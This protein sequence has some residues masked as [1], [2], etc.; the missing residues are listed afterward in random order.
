MKDMWWRNSLSREWEKKKEGKSLNVDDDDD[1]VKKFFLF[2]NFFYAFQGHFANFFAQFFSSFN[3]NSLNST[4]FTHGICNMTMTFRKI[5]EAKKKRAFCGKTFQ[6][7][8]FLFFDKFSILFWFLNFQFLNFYPLTRSEK[9]VLKSD[10]W[11]VLWADFWVT[12][13]KFSRIFFP[14]LN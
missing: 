1:V 12:V 3:F 10:G 5:S 7:L 13:R 8:E 6:T 11:E 4:K 2:W 9:W 14:H